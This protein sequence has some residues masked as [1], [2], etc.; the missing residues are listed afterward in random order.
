MSPE[1]DPI[2]QGDMA[3]HSTWREMTTLSVPNSQGCSHLSLAF[4]ICPIIHHKKYIAT[5][6][7]G[8]VRRPAELSLT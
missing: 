2:H 8:C 6:Q 5:I 4:F 1:A 7:Q 3:L